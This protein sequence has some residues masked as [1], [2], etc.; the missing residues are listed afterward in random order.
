MENMIHYVA[1]PDGK[2]SLLMESLW[3]EMLTTET[4]KSNNGIIII[5]VIALIL[6]A[7]IVIKKD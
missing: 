7:V 3:K 4:A 6:I 1:N 2:D 5:S